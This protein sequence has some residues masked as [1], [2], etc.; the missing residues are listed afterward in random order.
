[1]SRLT[2]CFSM[3]SDM[4]TRT[5][6]FS[7]SNSCSANALA[8]SVLP[9]PVG[10]R[11]MKEAMGLLGSA[12]PARLRCTASATASTASSCPITRSCSSSA[13][14]S[15]FSRSDWA[16]FC[17]GMPVQRATISA[18]SCSVT[19]SRS[20]L[21]LARCSSCASACSSCCCRLCREPYLSSA[22]RFRSYSRSACCISMLTASISSRTCWMRS[23]FSFSA[24]HWSLSARCFS[25]T[26]ASSASRDSRRPCDA[27]SAAAPPRVRL[28]FSI[29]SCMI[30]RSS[31]SKA[32]GLLVI[33]IFSL[34]PAS[35]TRSMALSGRNR[36]AMYRSDISAASTRAESEM[37]TP[38]CSS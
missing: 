16:S 6:S 19:S 13:R 35:S 37:D 26:P 10:P 11:N 29:S 8:S 2:A 7:L 17:T 23:M 32:W 25:C 28:S 36:S 30:L 3:Y 38:W 20:M 15:S 12:R 4:S 33:S 1:M 27:L 24:I 9:T 21:V 5:I 18:M 14:C 31:S 22:A 34:A